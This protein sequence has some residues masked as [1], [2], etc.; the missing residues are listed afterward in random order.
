MEQ[1]VRA[2]RER[3]DVVVLSCHWG[4]SGSSQTC[5]YQR[6]IARAAIA[7][8]ADVLIGHG[9]HHLQGVERFPGGDGRMGT[10]FYSLGNFAFDWT[11][12]RGREL[13]GLLVRCIVRQRRVAEVSF[14]P[15]RRDERNDPV[16]LSPASS[17]GARIVEEVRRLSQPWGTELHVERDAVLVGAAARVGGAGDAAQRVALAA[18]VN[19]SG[20]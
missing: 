12:M 16:P 9:P 10:V 13:D 11:K 8:G 20:R 17:E 3:A 14:I 2:L 4:V 7:A 5:D 1:D 15:V 18:G 19:G 6:G